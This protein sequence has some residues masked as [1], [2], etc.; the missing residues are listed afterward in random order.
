MSSLDLLKLG[1]HWTHTLKNPKKAIE[2]YFQGLKRVDI[3]DKC[4]ETKSLFLKNIAANYFSLGL[5][6]DS[7]EYSNKFV[8]FDQIYDKHHAK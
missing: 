8:E 4:K 3:E 1:N 7:L 2:Y 6:E 5:Y